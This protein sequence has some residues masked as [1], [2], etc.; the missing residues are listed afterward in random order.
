V[1]FASDAPLDRAQL[2]RGALG[3]P[4]LSVCRHVRPAP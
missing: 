3:L 2:A 4:R 1:A